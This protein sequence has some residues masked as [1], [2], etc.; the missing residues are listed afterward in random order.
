MGMGGQTWPQKELGSPESCCLFNLYQEELIKGS[1]TGEVGVWDG[2]RTW[3][4]HRR[5]TVIA[6]LLLPSR[7]GSWAHYL[8]LLLSFPPRTLPRTWTVK[9]LGTVL[10]ILTSSVP[11]ISLTILPDI[12]QHEERERWNVA[13]SAAALVA[14]TNLPSPHLHW[15]EKGSTNAATTT[16]MIS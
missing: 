8:P 14:T 4:Q 2:K 15:G 10:G 9:T 12:R 3:R 7:M 13:Y 16:A 1:R 11:H 6:E 5:I